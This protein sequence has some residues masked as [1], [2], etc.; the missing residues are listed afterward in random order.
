MTTPL[1]CFVLYPVVRLTWLRS[2]P[3]WRYWA[4]AFTLNN[5][6]IYGT[7]DRRR[8]APA[9]AG[10]ADQAAS[11]SRCSRE[12]RSIALDD[13]ETRAARRVPEGLSDRSKRRGVE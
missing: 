7:L 12:D 10:L 3:E 1:G 9:S 2:V 11:V 4:V 8:R 13:L 6:G 5:P